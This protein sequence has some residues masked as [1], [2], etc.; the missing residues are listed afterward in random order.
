MR[1]QPNPLVLARTLLRVIPLLTAQSFIL[2]VL[3]LAPARPLS[4]F[5]RLEM[6]VQHSLRDCK[7]GANCDAA[8]KELRVNCCHPIMTAADR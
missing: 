8:A 2:N 1:M 6:V 4:S 3:L 7:F 5:M